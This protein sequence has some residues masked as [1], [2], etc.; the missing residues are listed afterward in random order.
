MK[1]YQQGFAALEAIL[2][3]VVIVVI[4][5]T[6]YFVWHNK[7]ATDQ[8]LSD[9]N[10]ASTVSQAT[11]GAVLSFKSGVTFYDCMDAYSQSFPV[12][13]SNECLLA[14]KVYRTP[15][16]FSDD[17]IRRASK[18]MQF[19]VSESSYLRS[20]GGKWWFQKDCQQQ[21][22]TIYQYGRVQVKGESQGKYLL[23]SANCYDGEGGYDNVAVL[24]DGKWQEFPG[25]MGQSDDSSLKCDTI[26]KYAIPHSL[27]AASD[28]DVCLNDSNNSVKINSL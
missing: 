26:T 22:G 3:V 17:V 24:S 7:Q 21:I 9:T 11:Q 10:K 19:N 13:D 28:T 14:G 8:T 6:G 16:K 27:F 18:S 23:Y 12:K 2:I 15:A 20:V 25:S 4:G 5:G 1:K